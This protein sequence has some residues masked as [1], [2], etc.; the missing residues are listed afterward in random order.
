MMG[1]LKLTDEQ[2][3]T[4]IAKTAVISSL[5]VKA[6]EKNCSLHNKIHLEKTQM[7]I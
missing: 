6:V 4:G 2:R 5:E 7:D 3:R 1:W